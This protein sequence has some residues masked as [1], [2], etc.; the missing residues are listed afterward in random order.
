MRD[1]PWQ[2]KTVDENLVQRL[3]EDALIPRVLARLLILRGVKDRDG[4]RVWL[5]PQLTDLHPP[6]LLPD[7]EPA[8]ERIFQAI[9]KRERIWVWGHDD[10]DGMTAVVIML[11]VLKGLRA[12]VGYHIPTKGRDKH[13]LDAGLVAK[14]PVDERPGLIITVDCGISNHQDIE[15]LKQLG[16]DVIITDHHEIIPPLPSARAV[17]D[18]KR[19]DSDYPYPYLSGAGV[20]LKLGMGIIQSKL[21]VSVNE[22]FSALPDLLTFVTL[23]TVADRAPLTGENRILVKLGFER[24]FNSK[25]PAV[26]AVMEMLSVDCTQ[27]TVASF[28][29][30]ILPLFASA[31]GNEGVEKF[32]NG[33]LESVRVWVREMA[34]RSYEWRLEA[35]RTLAIA[36][37]NVRLGDGILFV[38]HPE[39]SLR[40]LGY[41]AGRL[42][43]RYQV[44]AIVMGQRGDIWVGE[45]RGIDGVDLM[46]LLRALRNYFIDFG[47]HQ[48]AAGFTILPERVP[49][50]I[51]AAERYAHENFATRI[52]PEN[53]VVADGV[54]PFSEFTTEITALAP[55]G[56]GNPQPVFISE[57]VRLVKMMHGLVPESNE[58]L[59]LN[60]GRDLPAIEPAL[61]YYALYTVDDSGGVTL[62]DV[63]TSA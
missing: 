26:Q 62:L 41:S 35:E 16:V 43:D 11:Q 28:L 46:E 54:L 57:P 61:E 37:K 25:V 6:S 40:A 19:Y 53:R 21:G 5:H 15:V 22:L 9:E 33:D 51:T 12:M 31:N 20:A 4:V 49:Y 34:H 45:C 48:K 58:Q 10:L 13:G 1:Y 17:V 55:F 30:E 60:P 24:L 50:F 47:G 18:P 14:I 3:A 2:I 8:V 32:L 23:G 27:L 56:D 52:V 44:P 38:Q 36:E 7:F 59:L 63:R 42:K 29:S 39:L